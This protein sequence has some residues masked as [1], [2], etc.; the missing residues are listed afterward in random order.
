MKSFLTGVTYDLFKL[1]QAIWNEGNEVRECYGR[2]KLMKFF[3][4]CFI[5]HVPLKR[6][7]KCNCYNQAQFLN[8][9]TIM[10]RLV[11]KNS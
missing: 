11:I 8:K 5:K 1:I 4:K 7:Y 2:L 9:E 10:K 3:I 6:F